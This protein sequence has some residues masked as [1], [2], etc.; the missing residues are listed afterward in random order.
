MELVRHRVF[1]FA[2]ESTRYCNYSSDKFGKHITFVKPTWTERGRQDSFNL[3]GID[4]ISEEKTLLEL[5]HACEAAYHKL[6]KAGQTPQEARAV[7]PNCLKTEV[8]MTGFMDQWE[9]FFKLRSAPTAHPDMQK[10]SKQLE[11]EYNI[12][13]RGKVAG[14]IELTAETKQLLEEQV[15]KVNEILDDGNQVNKE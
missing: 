14:D 5:L 4:F 6:I 10:V 9:A 2:Q 7:L 13:K 3:A 11:G 1:S 15:E 8:A 12:M